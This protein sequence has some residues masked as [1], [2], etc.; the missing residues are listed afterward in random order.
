MRPS[1]IKTRAAPTVNESRQEENKLSAN[2][3]PVNESEVIDQLQQFES[4][5]GIKR[6]LQVQYLETENT[7]LVLENEDLNTTLKI[8][9]DIIKTLLQ[10]NH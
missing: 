7:N 8:N 2:D 10:G 3:T 9:K 4:K 6:A 1:V 5:M